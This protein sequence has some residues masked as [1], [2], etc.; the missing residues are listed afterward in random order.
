MKKNH[1][2]IH[3]RS[4][5]AFSLSE[6]AILINDLIDLC[7]KNKMPALSLTDDGNLFGALEFATK[8]IKEGIPPIIGC[9]I[10][11]EELDSTKNRN[12]YNKNNIS[13]VLLLVENKIGWRNLSHL[14][15]KSFLDSKETIQRPIKMKELFIT[16]KVQKSLYPS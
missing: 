4:R 14:V 11:L 3:L 6:G 12:D 5:S 1:K 16:H 10:E 2:F 9:I 15:S 13:K 7:K 8:A